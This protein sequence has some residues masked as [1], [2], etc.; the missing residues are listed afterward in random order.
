[1]KI[2]AVV[3][4]LLL[5]VTLYAYDAT[6]E[7]SKN[8]EKRVKIALFDASGNTGT[9]NKQIYDMLVADFKTTGHFL[10][11]EG[12]KRVNESNDAKYKEYD[13][14][15]K[16]K[17]SMF[18]NLT[19]DVD[20]IRASIN[21][22]VHSK[23]FYISSQ[24]RYPFL[25]HSVVSQINEYFGFDSVDWMMNYVIFSKKTGLNRSDIF[26]SDYT[27]TFQKKV[28]SGGINIFPKWA[29]DKK[30]EFYYTSMNEKLP[31]LYKVN[32][33]SGERTK[34][35]ANE[36]ML[37]C[38]D[39]RKNGQE[40]LLTVAHNDQPEIYLYNTLTHRKKRLTYFSGIDVNAQFVEGD[41]IVFISDRLGYPNVYKKHLE[42]T[43]VRQ[44]VFHGNNNHAVTAHGNYMVYVSRDSDNAFANNSFN[45]YLISTKSSYIRPLTANGVNQFPKFSASG[46]TVLFI[47]NYENESALGIIRINQN[48]SYLFPLKGQK[49]Q[50]IDW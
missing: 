38:S 48:K 45:L 40:L 44:M 5:S 8:L 9:I 32:L 25:A 13:Y 29:D 36:G 22:K 14:L 39:T 34:I 27:L 17:L 16:F 4:F 42:G 33:Y 20:I 10:V 43:D 7:I 6:I 19:I 35:M 37:I 15:V 12:Y 21:Q 50:S 30:E 41:N 49:L 28:V 11:E 23:S 47:K 3:I 2:K 46:D 24:E 31:T 26:I 1:L 18:R